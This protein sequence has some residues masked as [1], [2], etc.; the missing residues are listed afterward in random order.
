MKR[1]IKTIAFV[2]LFLFMLIQLYQPALNVNQGQV[3][4]TDFVQFYH[5]PAEIGNILAKSC[6]D[7]H[8]NN[9]NYKWYDYVQPVR[10]LVEKHIKAAK[11]D[12]NFSEWSQYPSRKQERL[13]KSI[14]KQTE[15][16]NMPLASYTLMH[17]NTSLDATQ[18]KTLTDWLEK[19]K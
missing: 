9:T 15:S 4:T 14:K 2:L 18:V 16:K 1:K 7:C 6:Y 10:I 17:K 12:L 8:S 19:Q 11:K 13:L 3:G 5:A